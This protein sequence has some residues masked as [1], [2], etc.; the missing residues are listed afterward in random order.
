[1]SIRLSK[2]MME[3]LRKASQLRPDLGITGVI[4]IAMRLW[5]RDGKPVVSD[6]ELLST[7]YGGEVV[8]L[9]FVHIPADVRMAVVWYLERENIDQITPLSTRD[10]IEGIDYIIEE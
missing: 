8:R 5:T 2:Q 10:E 3:A 4:R 6:S 7:T 9:P 1:M